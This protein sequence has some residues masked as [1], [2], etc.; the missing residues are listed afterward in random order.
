M[1]TTP[2]PATPTAAATTAP[3]LEVSRLGIEFRTDEGPVRAVDRVDF[4]IGRGRVLGIVGESGSGKTV[5]AQAL[6]RLLP[7]NARLDPESR[8]V[9]HSD[10][11]PTEITALDPRG[12]TIRRIRGGRISMV[13]QEPMASF[14]PVYTIGNQLVEAIRLH[15]PLGKAE[16]KEVAIDML[17]RVGI[18]NPA[19][20]FE[21]YAFELSG[22]MRQR[23]MIAVALVTEPDLLIADE[24]TTALDVT[25]QAQIL[26]LLG[27][28]QD[29][30]GM[31]VIFITHDLGVISKIAD[32]I[33][34]MYLGRVMEEGTAVDVITRPAHPYTRRLLEAIPRLSH[35]G[36]RLSAI[37]GD[38]PAPSARPPG[39][40]FHTR[41]PDV[42]PGRCD[43]VVPDPV[44]TD[45]GHL[46][47][48]LLH[49]AADDP[50]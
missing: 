33:L 6:M 4:S 36:E 25:I 9:L 19:R 44:A 30:M 35:L 47:H 38:I 17:A 26:E 34:V 24:P 15:R 10:D 7:R 43:V 18:S 29:R 12:K 14:S 41:C 45:P 23:A 13:F 32:D 16:A 3:L 48:C 42:M 5:T 1:T 27:D 20:R 49:G 31:A 22:G 37:P 46:V 2:T 50:A 39:C 11:G 28:L 40:P 8:I 21:Q